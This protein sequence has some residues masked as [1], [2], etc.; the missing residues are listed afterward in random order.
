MKPFIFQAPLSVIFH[1]N[2]RSSHVTEILVFFTVFIKLV[3]RSVFFFIIFR[4][5]SDT[6]S[7]ICMT[8][9]G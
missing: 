9:P 8:E 2:N 3:C 7:Q 6:F 5:K 4:R 1:L